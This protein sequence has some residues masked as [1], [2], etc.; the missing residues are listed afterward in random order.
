[1]PIAPVCAGSFFFSSRNH[2]NPDGTSCRGN[3]TIV[4]TKQRDIVRI[5]KARGTPDNQV[6]SPDGC[7]DAADSP[8]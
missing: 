4:A 1:M 3:V 2:E 8:W 7:P 5:Q 6:W